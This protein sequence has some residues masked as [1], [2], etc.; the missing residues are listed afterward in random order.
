VPRGFKKDGPATYAENFWDKRSFLSLDDHALLYGKDKS[1]QRHQIFLHAN[2]DGISEAE[3]E[4]HHVRNEHNNFRR[5]DCVEGGLW[6][7][8]G[9]AKTMH[10]QTKFSRKADAVKDFNAL[11]PD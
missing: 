7:R 8:K 10:V 6:V 3:G 5:C 2:P 1:Q 4:W 11:Y 9:H